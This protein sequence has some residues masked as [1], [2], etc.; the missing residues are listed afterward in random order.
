MKLGTQLLWLG[1]SALSLPWAAWV[2]V[3]ELERLLREGQE[4]SQHEVSRTL[5]DAL[6]MTVPALETSRVGLYVRPSATAPTLDGFATDWDQQT[7]AQSLDPQGH[8]QLRLQAQQQRLFLWV[9]VTDTTPERSQ[10]NGSDAA[11][12]DHLQLD[13]QSQGTWHAFAIPRVASGPVNVRSTEGS[14]VQGAWQERAD[15]YALELALPAALTAQAIRLTA[16]DVDGMRRTQVGSGIA[17]PLMLPMQTLS[18]ALQRLLPPQR[19]GRVFDRQQRPIAE[20]GALPDEVAVSAWRRWLSETLGADILSSESLSGDSASS[21]AAE[22]RWQSLLQGQSQHVWRVGDAG[23]WVLE[24]WTPIRTESGETLA[25]LALQSS[26]DAL[27]LADR[28]RSRLLWSTLAAALLVAAVLVTYSIHL[29]A[30]IR[31]LHRQAEQA[32]LREGR[33]E[34]AFVVDQRSDELG[35]LSRSFARLLHEI[36]AY[37]QYLRTLA[38]SLSHELHTPLAVVRSSLD[39]LES[40][41]RDEQSRTWLQR[42][43]E[44]VTR[45]ASLLRAMSEAT[46]I[47]RAMAAAEAEDF[48]LVPM[49]RQCA[50]GW[51]ALE[52]SARLQWRLELP[53]HCPFHGAPDLIVQALEKLVDNARSFC[54][55]GGHIQ[56]QLSSHADRILLA[57]CNDGPPLPEGNPARLF[58]SLVSVRNAQRN[59]GRAPHLGLGLHIVRLVCE[60]HGGFATAENRN[61][62]VC[63]TLHL[64]GMP[65]QR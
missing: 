5:A 18:S 29:S 58:D 60:L 64:R 36:D 17:Q 11:W 9:E 53:P 32:L 51:A 15:G 47:E 20:A 7:A 50:A 6:S 39:N 63:F 43:Q 38:G 31:R 44:G 35:D 54:P 30:R 37:T 52:E 22:P 24:T 23:Q 41:A 57:V 65:R 12:A 49:L 33:A 3:G 48:D 16:I 61:T 1:L 8:L 25:V 42:A 21:Q 34:S 19:L 56:I 55:P 26:S 14:T 45:L 4:Q 27:L 46:R 62:G 13:V 59:A 2:F 40:Q 10:G 28:A